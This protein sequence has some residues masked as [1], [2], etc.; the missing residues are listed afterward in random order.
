MNTLTEVRID[1]P[2]GPKT[3]SVHCGEIRDLDV[4]LDVMTV[5]AFFRDYEPVP[6]TLVGT[7]RNCGIDI[8]RLSRQP[9]A[10]LRDLCDIWLSEE[11]FRARLPIRRIGCIEM[12]SYSRQAPT[13]AQRAANEQAIL[14][15]IKAYFALLDMATAAGIPVR[16]LG[17][18][19]PGGGNQGIATD[20]TAIPVIN[21][22]FAYL[23]RN[24]DT[25]HIR[26][27]TH[28]QRQAAEFAQRIDESYAVLSETQAH[29]T[30]QNPTTSSRTSAPLVFLSYSSGDKNVADNLCA[31]LESAGM[32]VWYAPRDVVAS[33]YASSIVRAIDSCTHFVVILSKNSLASEHVLNEI[34]LAFSK[35]RNGMHFAPLKIDEE[36][37]GP[38]FRYYLSRQHWMDARVPPLEKRLD[39]FVA[40]LI[41][42]E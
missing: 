25:E 12:S 7:L 22:C 34:D 4:P 3:L 27:I 10:D 19:I 42:A 1:S 6:G 39:E 28:N 15:S 20:L 18:P 17:L 26:I 14:R 33:D 5:S 16:T 38:A 8:K 2:F 24:Q 31:K 40:K 30:T 13:S 32:R 29:D 11:V 21:E 37:L 35:L 41:E 36:E 9:V 23:R